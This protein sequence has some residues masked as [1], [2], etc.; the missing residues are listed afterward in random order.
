MAALLPVIASVCLGPVY[1]KQPKRDEYPHVQ[2]ETL[3]LTD[4]VFQ[5]VSSKQLVKFEKH[6]WHQDDV[7]LTDY[8]YSNPQPVM[9]PLDPRAVIHEYRKMMKEHVERR[10]LFFFQ[11]T[12]VCYQTKL[13]FE[14]VG[15]QDQA[16]SADAIFTK[17][18]NQHTKYSKR[19]AAHSAGNPCI[20][21]YDPVQWKE[22]QDGKRTKPDGYVYLKGSDVYRAA[23]STMSMPRWMNEADREIDEKTTHSLLRQKGED[24]LNRVAHG[25]LTPDEGMLEYID[26]ALFEVQAA[27]R[28][29]A[30]ARKDEE[31]QL[32]LDYYERYLTKIKRVITQDPLFLEKFLGLMMGDANQDQ[33]SRKLIFQMRYAAIRGCQVNQAALMQKIEGVRK[34]IL[35]Q[36]GR[37]PDNFNAA[38]KMI[39]IEQA[40]TDDDRKRLEKLL[41]FSPANFVAQIGGGTK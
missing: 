8:L 1:A 14:S 38:F 19:N 37:K 4:R 29:L 40:R 34:Q 11:Q 27:K 17:T 30:Q 35:A 16:D 2:S 12:I 33:A 31:E 6:P 7:R 39:V 36:Y 22:Y 32:V 18:G 13:H 26:V 23:N 3:S 24:I 9:A 21:A 5:D 20:V 41:N 10:I 15:A 25:A 28:R